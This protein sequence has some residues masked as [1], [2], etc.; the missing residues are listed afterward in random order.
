MPK[1]IKDT[2]KYIEAIRWD[3][4]DTLL[5]IR[6]RILDSWGD[7]KVKFSNFASLVSKFKGKKISVL[8][9]YFWYR[10]ILNEV[11][12]DCVVLSSPNVIFST[13][14]CSGDK[15]TDE[16]S[17]QAPIPKQWTGKLVIPIT[18]IEMLVRPNF[19]L[20][21]LK[22]KKE[23]FNWASCAGELTGQKDNKKW[24]VFKKYI[25]E[26]HEGNR[27][28]ILCN[29]YWYRGIVKKV[30]N[31]CIVLEKGIAVEIAGRP[32]DAKSQVEDWIGSDVFIPRTTIEM[33]CHPKWCEAPLEPNEK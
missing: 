13:G 5:E 1:K 33:I 2:N 6:K 9:P 23:I 7:R 21:P 3:K 14:T 4:K 12:S 18:A 27:V 10:G 26:P 30:A 28:A 16:I 11:T 8:C 17:I 29:R 24:E 31:D 19:C 25:V 22:A 32:E 20:A 15:P